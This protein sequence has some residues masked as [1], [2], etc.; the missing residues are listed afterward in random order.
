MLISGCTGI[1]LYPFSNY[2]YYIAI[3]MAFVLKCL[4]PLVAKNF[5]CLTKQSKCNCL[6]YIFK[7]YNS[8]IIRYVICRD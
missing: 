8:V 3:D 6:C 7:Y 2:Y 1:S 4:W 5:V